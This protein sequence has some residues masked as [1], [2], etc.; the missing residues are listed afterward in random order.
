MYDGPEFRYV[1]TRRDEFAGSAP[2]AIICF[3]DSLP[4]GR[5]TFN[6]VEAVQVVQTHMLN[7]LGFGEADQDLRRPGL[8]MEIFRRLINEF[9]GY[10]IR[11]SGE[12]S[13]MLQEVHDF[14]A[15]VRQR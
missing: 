13:G 4:I 11:V 5:F 6:V 1:V 3:Y 10:E 12:V 9:P 2:G 15:A 7:N 8:G 14:I